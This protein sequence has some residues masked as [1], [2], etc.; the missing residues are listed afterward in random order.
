[1]YNIELI[2]E[3]FYVWMPFLIVS[4]A[5]IDLLHADLADKLW[6]RYMNEW[7]MDL[8]KAPS[9]PD[10]IWGDKKWNNFL[11]SR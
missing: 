10:F 1:M 9:V 7:M 11:E 6:W 2:D 3:L 4:W 5:I 8:R